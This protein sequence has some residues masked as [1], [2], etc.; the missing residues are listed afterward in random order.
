MKVHIATSRPIGELCI[1]WAKD[2][3]PKGV[4]L[5]S[6]EECDVFISVMY[7]KLIDEAYIN[8]RKAC[9]NIHPGILPEYRGSGAYSWAIINGEVESGITLHII[10]VSIDHGPIIAIVRFAIGKEDTA[11]TLF[12]KAEDAM[13]G[14]FKRSFAT[15]A[16]ENP[17]IYSQPQEEATAHTYYRKELH[18]VRDMTRY[19]RAFTFEGKPNAFYT[20]RKGDIVE[21]EY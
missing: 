10:D 13:F 6:M 9:Y 18:D 2:H 3:L 16:Q 21:L 20:N 5:S 8:S 14:L 11:Q 12:M 15:L 17:V 7:D 19:V 1:A 4:E